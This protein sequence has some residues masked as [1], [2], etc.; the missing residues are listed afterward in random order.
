MANR[1]YQLAAPAAKP[2]NVDNH[3]QIVVHDHAGK[4][5]N[6]E[7]RKDS[8]VHSHEDVSPNGADQ[9]E[10]NGRHHDEGLKIGAKGNGQQSVNDEERQGVAAQNALYGFLLLLL[11]AF[12]SA[13][14][15]GIFLFQLWKIIRFQIGNDLVGVGFGGVH[16][17]GH[18]N[19]AP[20][21]HSLDF[22]VSAAGLKFGRLSEGN[23]RSGRR[24]NS[25]LLQISQRST[26]RLRITHH[27][28]H[29]VA[30]AL[31]ALGFFAVKG[32]P[33]L[34]TQI[35]LRQSQGFGAGTD[36]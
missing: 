20:P 7:H 8:E 1:V 12:P 30:A 3:H 6:A 10:R 24:S 25:H 16:V 32:L 36:G 29:F 14:D 9:S 18:I 27:N 28:A 31:D 35:H 5:D 34:A 13:R 17:R 2:I 11:F 33:H 26:L 15:S 4:G 21:I 23:F 19:G 22:G